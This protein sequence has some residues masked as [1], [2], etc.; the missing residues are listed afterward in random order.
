[1]RGLVKKLNVL[2]VM[3]AMALAVVLGACDADSPTAP[4]QT[5][6]PD[7]TPSGVTGFSISVSA[8]P[9]ALVIDDGVVA[10]VTVVARRTDN[11]QP[12][13]EGSTAVL[14][15][16][17]GT[18]GNLAGTV[19]G[20]SIAVAFGA[21]GTALA[22]LTAP[23]QDAIV[24]AQIN[25]S[26]GQTRVTVTE[27]PVEL[28]LE[29]AAV[30]PNF[31]PPTGGTE[32][33][34]QG[35]GFSEPASVTFGGQ[36]VQI[37]SLS[38][39]SITVLTPQVDLPSGQNLAVAVAVDVN[40]GEEGQASDVL[41]GGFTFTRND[42]SLIPKIIS[43]T[44]TSGP[45]EGGTEV[46]IFG[47]AFGPEVQVFFGTSRIEAE[48]LD[49]SST[50]ILVRTPPAT[51]QNASNQNATVGIEVFDL[52]S[53]FSATRANAFQFGGGAMFISSIEPSEGTYFGGTLVTI[54]GNGFEAPA[55]VSF[56]GRAQQEV[57]VSGTEIIARSI[58]PV[59]INNCNRPA[60]AFTVVN[61]E[62]NETFTSPLQFTY[63]PVEPRI[64]S[65]SESSTTA[66]VDSGVIVGLPTELTMTGSGF[67]RQGFP[68]QVTFGNE[69]SSVT[70]TSLDS[71][72]L[73]IGNGVGDV[74]RIVIPPFPV[75]FPEE[76]CE[77]PAGTGMRFA[78]ARVDITVTNRS[79]DCVDTASNIFTYF[80]N[81]TT[82]RVDTVLPTAA[83]TFTV[84]GTAVTVRDR[85]TGAPEA[86]DWAWG[87]GAAEAGIPGELSRVHDYGVSGTFTVTLTAANSAGS[88]FV[89]MDVT[90]P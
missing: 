50:R 72:P 1:M 66:D 9:N 24:R 18:L 29:V 81:D 22:N 31:G 35:A 30:T 74:M 25:Q 43:V 40:I 83:F 12:V 20:E 10:R 14:S 90:I 62:T 60:G 36:S 5:P 48:V 21:N 70:V 38:S 77:T 87:D 39:S 63:R 75:P 52:R 33:R 53:G 16:T 32:V 3:P 68:P 85:S 23:L 59:E 49:R 41:A 86:I 13:P 80:P 73:H 2:R 47:E 28:P 55:A 78:E 82:C 11:G 27:A 15:T 7:P 8:N 42:T 17:S 6:N 61:I 71:D 19:L 44:P 34:I 58:G 69:R 84:S 65:I 79:T 26:A 64:G 67:D 89:S 4:D 37:L 76:E 46:T 54:F 57:S 88:T 56:G 51:G 45:N